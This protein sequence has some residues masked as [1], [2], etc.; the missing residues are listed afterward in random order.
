MLIK[1]GSK[2]ALGGDEDKQQ[3]MEG[4]IGEI[5]FEGADCRPTWREKQMCKQTVAIRINKSEPGRKKRE[6]E[7]EKRG[8]GGWEQSGRKAQSEKTSSTM[9]LSQQ[10]QEKPQQR[11]RCGRENT[12]RGER[13]QMQ[14]GARHRDVERDGEE[15]EG[16]AQR[17]RE[18]QRKKKQMS[19]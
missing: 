2:Q 10:R 9:C 8:R 13:R 12:P 4:C 14:K 7:R 6:R 17:L 16:D 3:R 18:M 5:V 1:E 11:K 19:D 15:K